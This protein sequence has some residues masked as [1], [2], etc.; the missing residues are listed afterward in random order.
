MRGHAAASEAEVRRAHQKFLEVGE[1]SA[2]DEEK[3]PVENLGKKFVQVYA[4]VFPAKTQHVRPLHPAERIHEV[5]VVLGL[6]LVGRRSRA[7]LETRTPKQ[8][9]LVNGLGDFIGRPVEAQV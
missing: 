9:E 8:R 3:L 6:R 7:N 2:I 5:V 4:R 1:S